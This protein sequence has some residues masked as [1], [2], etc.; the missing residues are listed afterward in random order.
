MLCLKY[1]GRISRVDKVMYQEEKGSDKVQS[2]IVSYWMEETAGEV[3]PAANLSVSVMM[4]ASPFSVLKQN[5][6]RQVRRHDK[7]SSIRRW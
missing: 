4:K 3:L 1:F 6:E 2:I 5:V 7:S